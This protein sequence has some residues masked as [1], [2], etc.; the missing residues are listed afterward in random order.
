M[1]TWVK[2]RLHLLLFG[3]L[4]YWVGITV[5]AQT[6]VSEMPASD[7]STNSAAATSDAQV[8]LSE[9]QL[10]QEP[11]QNEPAVNFQATPP[12]SPSFA[13]SSAD[14]TKL[15]YTKPASGTGSQL[16]TVFLSLVFIV[17]LIY[18]LSLFVRKFGQ[19]MGYSSQHIKSLANMSVGTRERIV[20]I[21]VGDK[22]I[23]V[24][25]TPTQINAL[26][27]FDSPVVEV[28]N[29]QPAASDFAQK[30]KAVLSAHIQKPK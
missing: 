24:G 12:L 3:V 16:L 5:L 23:L 29:T 8:A 9:T 26:H 4:F 21:E 27:V 10:T 17:A 30:F 15:S 6:P 1:N 14:A 19:G 18:G 11:A 28:E 13:A 25:V 22:Q 7:K 20:L 2:T